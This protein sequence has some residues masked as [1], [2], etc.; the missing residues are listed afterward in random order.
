VREGALIEVED[1]VAGYA[2]PVV[3]PVS[4]GVEPG[5]VVG[6]AGPNG[7]GKSTLLGAIV[8]SV[9]VFSGEV[10]KRPGLR[11]GIQS[12]R[13]TQFQEM[14]LTGAD[15]L[16]ITGADACGCPPQLVSLLPK[17]LD[18][19]SGGQYQL[20]SVWACLGCRSDLAILDE[21][22]NNMDPTAVAT[23]T[24][25]VIVARGGG[26]GLLIVS[27][28]H[29]FLEQASTRLVEVRRCR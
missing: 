27:H 23:L 13:L 6:L 9:R 1:L 24:E 20:L 29:E 2:S 28:D 15:L 18:G 17:R 26:R 16:H 10:R 5:D 19:L 14:P 22:T 12:Q 11:V 7:A 21:P 25:I 4:F 8:G 3:G